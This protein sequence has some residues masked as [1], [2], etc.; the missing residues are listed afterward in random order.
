MEY[1]QANNFREKPQDNILSCFEY[2][3]E[4]D[5]VER[6]DVY[7]HVNGVTKADAFTQFD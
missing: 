6:M 7:I 1:L 3:Y 4:K 5:G 2:V